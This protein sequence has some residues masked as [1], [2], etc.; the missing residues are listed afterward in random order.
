MKRD[1]P[2]DQVDPTRAK[3]FAW[4]FVRP[5][6]SE[7]VAKL[8]LAMGAA[9]E[10]ALLRERPLLPAP[11]SDTRLERSRDKMRAA[12]RALSLGVAEAWAA[13]EVE[14]SVRAT[15]RLLARA[16]RLGVALG[17]MQAHPAEAVRLLRL[18]VR[19]MSK[20]TRR[21]RERASYVA[22]SMPLEHPEVADLLV[23]IARAADRTMAAA[24]L[25]DD[26]WS[27]EIGDIDALVARLADVVDEGPSDDS[28]AVAVDLLARIE[29]RAT[30]VVALRRALRQPSF[31]VRSHALHA[32][33]AAAPPAVAPDDLVLVLRD[34]VTNP[35]PDILACG[36]DVSL[37]DQL[38]E[39]ER[40]MAEG[41]ITAL[42]HVQP[43][44]A[45]EALLDLIDAEHEV[46]WLDA[47]WATEA[48]AA[49]FPET[50]AAMVDHWLKCAR[51]HERVR[52]LAALERLPAQLAL[53]RLRLAASDP[54]FAVR[55]GARRQWLRRFDSG[56][57]VG[58]ESALGA[59]LLDQ[60][61]SDRFAARLAVMQ[62]RVS[63]A[64]R[65]MARALLAE[66]PDPEALVLLLQ[67][68]A[69]DSDP[70][71]LSASSI[72]AREEALAP[73]VVE[74]FGPIGVRGVCAIAK[75]FPE[76]ESFG[77][78]RRLGDL[79]ERGTIAREHAEPVRALAA[80]QVSSDDAG[81]VDDALRVLGLL[82]APPELLER[83]LALALDD[84]IGASEARSLVI[85]WPDRAIDARLASEMALSLAGRDWMRLRYAAWMA[86]DR[87]A[88]AARVIAQRVL[89][90][91][92][93]DSEAVDAAVE[94][95]R[96]L[97]EA[98]VL[99]EAW[100][101][102]ALARPSSPIFAV[103]ARAWRR[104]PGVRA[105]LESAMTSKARGGA[106]AVQAAISLLHGDPG[107]S[108]RDR[109]LGAV[110]ASAGAP[111]RAELVHAMCMHGAPLSV[112][113]P[114][115]E[116]LLVSSDPNVSGP[117]VGIG[118]W[119][120]SPK[121]RALLRSLLPRVVDLELRTD[122]EDAL[123]THDSYRAL[124]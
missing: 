15:K 12:C 30:T 69:D 13:V 75:R 123:A 73:R 29:R 85:S 112:V 5:G 89:E 74:R 105:S 63:E 54:A 17:C 94:C 59:E 80:R 104:D 1:D 42:A 32:L 79:V 106:S 101:L 57:P 97:R 108:P 51:S 92:E 9:D 7:G 26:A 65:A 122:I 77:W 72:A 24:L 45:E 33:A 66:A 84:E 98:G 50:A 49:A 38:E 56:C 124:R 83:I 76:P 39:D 35:P 90:V 61:P 43:A 23:E 31:A 47:G 64:R 81:R 110:L 62:G 19:H 114:H 118:V 14:A 82:G 111:E 113:G 103:A 119:L 16:D 18:V 55:D 86:L 121:A 40:M 120:K 10:S 88:P 34:M 11:S 71:E 21:Q 109:R 48:L 67:L 36:D 8:L 37:Q 87:G 95:A 78:M 44:E 27:V 100:V 93:R 91:A 2:R 46:G 58:A 20:M 116:E 68:V 41:V 96:R 102:G 28:R 6:D 99:D 3:H 107:L 25:E 52:A 117:L 22:G 60:P 53:P 115:L 4:S 70:A